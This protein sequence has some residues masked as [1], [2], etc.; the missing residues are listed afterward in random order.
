[1]TD[2]TSTTLTEPSLQTGPSSFGS[3]FDAAGLPTVHEVPHHKASHD[4]NNPMDHRSTSMNPPSGSRDA[5]INSSI[6]RSYNEKDMAAEAP[7]VPYTTT[8]RG[9]RHV[10]QKTDASSAKL[11]K[12][13]RRNTMGPQ[14]AEPTSEQKPRRGG[15]RNTIRRIFGRRSMKD[16]IS[17]PA[18]PVYQR[19]V[20]DLSLSCGLIADLIT[21][22]ESGRVYHVCN[23]LRNEGHAK[24]TVCLRADKYFPPLQRSKLTSSVPTSTATP[25]P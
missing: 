9:S 18:G 14:Y 17:M 11:R 25:R 7:Q 4:S 22:T 12:G 19:H 3:G 23:R 10:I 2:S 13:D 6:G 15:L 21:L 24:R 8:A 1:M 16:R 5:S 20:R